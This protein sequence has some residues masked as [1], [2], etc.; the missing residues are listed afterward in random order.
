MQRR[1]AG[2]S[3]CQCQMLMPIIYTLHTGTTGNNP[4]VVINRNPMGA[5]IRYNP[6]GSAA[7]TK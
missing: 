4:P 3:L 5:L 6:L 1:N 2:S 7:N